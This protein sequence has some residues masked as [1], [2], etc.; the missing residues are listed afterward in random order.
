MAFNPLIYIYVP[1]IDYTVLYFLLFYL[2]SSQGLAL[3]IASVSGS[4][5]FINNFIDV[6]PTD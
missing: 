3:W 6:Q 1:Y 4:P 2:N 5:T